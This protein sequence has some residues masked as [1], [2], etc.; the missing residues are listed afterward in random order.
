MGS[1]SDRPAAVAP[2]H[3]KAR[4]STLAHSPSSV[5]LPYPGG[6]TMSTRTGCGVDVSRA[7]SSGRGT[8]PSG[9]A[10]A[11]PGISVRPPARGSGETE[12]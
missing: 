8:K 3:T 5:D 12:S 10:N 1:R 7:T 9:N 2:N 11:L 4:C 6:A